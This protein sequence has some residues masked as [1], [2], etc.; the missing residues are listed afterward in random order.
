[1][2]FHAQGLFLV[3]NFQ[4]NAE[5][6]QHDALGHPTSGRCTLTLTIGYHFWVDSIPPRAIDRSGTQGC[7]WRLQ[8][9]GDQEH[10]LPI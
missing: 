5:Q 7:H 8:T 6:A 9:R 4:G 2:L 3:S 10:M 1:M